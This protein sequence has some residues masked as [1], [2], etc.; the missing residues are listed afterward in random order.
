MSAEF[1]IENNALI[2]CN[3]AE[4]SETVIIPDGVEKI[5]TGAFEYCQCK[6]IIIPASVKTLEDFAFR[7]C[8]QLERIT[9][10]ATVKTL[11]NKLFVRCGSLREITISEGI[12]EITLYMFAECGNL[13]TVHL[14]ESLKSIGVSSFSRCRSLREITIPENVSSIGSL[15]FLVCDSLKTIH[16]PKSLAFIGADAFR[17]CRDLKRVEMPEHVGFIGKGAFG[18]ENQLCFP[19]PEGELCVDIEYQWSE[20]RDEHLLLQ[21]INTN[22]FNY[23]EKI[24]SVLK[25]YSYKASV[26]LWM[27]EHYPE[28]KIYQAYVKRSIKRIMEHLIN[29]SNIDRIEKVLSFGYVT[30]KNIDSLLEFAINHQKHEAYLTLLNYKNEVIGY[31]KN[32]FRI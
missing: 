9:I 5:M 2:Q 4:L 28:Q 13:A 15:A 31:R 20:Q 19:M 14:P 12:T 23:R 17:G 16:L 25:T 8:S 7:D 29:T 30:K 11:R 22:D 24:F 3:Q 27:V 6:E 26:A 32:L 10:P 1:I 21:F 18:A